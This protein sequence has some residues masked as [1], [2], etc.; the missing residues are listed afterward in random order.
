MRGGP[1]PPGMSPLVPSPE[2]V[3]EEGADWLLAV[4][5]NQNLLGKTMLVLRRPCSA[6]ADVDAAE[7]TSLHAELARV[8]RALQQLFRL[9]Q[10]NYAFLMNMDAQVHLH[11]IP[12]YAAPRMWSGDEFT[13]PNWGS[14]FGHEQRPLE[15][16]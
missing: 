3:V 8:T 9:D 15:P 14:A 4:N 5:R 11:V 6:V 2:S 12:R 1:Y 7:W 10:M 16:A 13:D